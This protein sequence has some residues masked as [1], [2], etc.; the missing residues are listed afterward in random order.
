VTNSKAREVLTD[1]VVVDG[2]TDLPSR[3]YYE[4]A[5]VARRLGSGH[6]DLPR[7][8]EGGVDAIVAALYVPSFLG[9]E[10]G[11]RHALDLHAALAGQLRPGVF[12]QAV[13]AEEV[14]RAAA[15]GVPAAILG[16]EN[17]RPLLVSGALEQCA[18]LGVRYVTPTHVASHEWC[19]AAGDEPRH[20]G[21]SDV[22]VELVRELRRR[23]ILI[24]VSHVSDDA[25]LHVL[26]ALRGPVVASHSSARAR[27][28]HPRN[29]SDGLVREIARRGG[30]VMANSYPAFL[31][32]RAARANGER[33]ARLRPLL[34]E[35]DARAAAG[36]EPDP[37]AF[38]ARA[39]ELLGD[40]PLPPVPLAAY[41][42]HL[43]HLVEVAG[44]EHVGI[45]TDF[46]GITD[47]LEGFAD[48]SR[49]PALVEALLDRGLSRAALGL[50]LGE[51][52]LRLLEDAERRAE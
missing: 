22:G 9:P 44:E 17:G 18:R 5:D 1:A 39:R 50:I 15:A 31:D 7:M 12:A 26:D 38:R 45:G 48:V 42:D 2:H 4:P 8:R 24:D 11:W 10:R 33:L 3:L 36:I 27:C 16:L 37:L 40:S 23:G 32:A 20:G 49:F 13:T 51:N 46:D 30:V 47:T 35:V 6:V 25:V 19:D 14:R 21:L 41:V 52:F 43:V 34:E 28:D 29:L